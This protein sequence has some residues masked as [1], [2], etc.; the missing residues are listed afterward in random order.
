MFVA[1]VLAFLIL[2]LSL[3][4]LVA[5]KYR[6]VFNPLLLPHFQ[7]I[8]MA[9]LAPLAQLALFGLQQPEAR[10]TEASLLTSLYV[11]GLSL[12]L[13]CNL[14][15]LLPLLRAVLRP[16]EVVRRERLSEIYVL[17]A[18]LLGIG[19][20]GSFLL[21]MR[22]SPAGWNWISDPR[23]SYITGRAG[24][25]HWYVSSQAC[26]FLSL[27]V[28]LYFRRIRNP[29]LLGG[30]AL[31][32][33]F[34]FAYFGSKTGMLGVLAATVLYYN[35]YVRPIGSVWLALAGAAALPVV[36]I[37]PWLQG[38]FD[39]LLAT[40]TYY[41]YF[42]NAA[43]YLKEA[44][45]IG[46]RHGSA[47]LSSFWEYVP[48]G[49]YPE[50]P[51]IYGSLC[52]NEYFWPGSAEVGYTPALLPWTAY[53]LDFGVGG[54]L[55]GAVA[56]GFLQKAVYTYFLSTRSF[57]A[58][59]TLLQACFIPVLKFSPALYYAALLLCLTA[60]LRMFVFGVAV[61][62]GRQAIPGAP[63]RFFSGR[64]QP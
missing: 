64:M 24:V 1:A 23:M 5:W 25:G 11:F 53:Y 29:M 37:S 57:V 19:F 44:D 16:V 61:A 18:G 9:A 63:A 26:L 4:G 58:F 40:L 45:R 51:F 22:D 32:Y 59:V 8:V 38:S 36:C 6:S 43:M 34:L 48:R 35:Y 30:L 20:V 13:L 31:G 28:L 7:L 33:A 12:P 50:K 52:I 14:N 3:T 47:A 41:D 42:D 60:G 54:V 17:F 56:T 10:L 21:L 39:N 2:T 49:L 27:L 62:A 15:P 46:L 55:A